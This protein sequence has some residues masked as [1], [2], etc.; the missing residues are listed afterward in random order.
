MNAFLSPL[1][2]FKW[3]AIILA[4]LSFVVCGIVI[5]NFNNEGDNNYHFRMV[6]NCAVGCIVLV[7]FLI[8][9]IDRYVTKDYT[10]LE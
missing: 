2:I 7:V 4:V 6:L 9:V 5:Y 10:I 1:V 8:N 3:L